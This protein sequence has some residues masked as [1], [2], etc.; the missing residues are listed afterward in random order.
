[1][2]VHAELAAHVPGGRL[3]RARVPRRARA[4]GVL[5][6][7]RDRLGLK[8]PVAAAAHRGV[9]DVI[10]LP[11]ADDEL[12]VSAGGQ[13]E[14][15]QREAGDLQ[16]VHGR[17]RRHRPERALDDLPHRGLEREVE[18][19][20]VLQAAIVVSVRFRPRPQLASGLEHRL[21]RVQRLVQV[22]KPAR[23]VQELAHPRRRHLV[24][25]RDVDLL[26]LARVLVVPEHGLGRAV[27]VRAG[28]HRLERA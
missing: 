15:F 20:D 23:A 24:D 11:E 4:E 10:P 26:A 14:V 9:D 8:R 28:V 21:Q 17:A 13:R 6:A 19:D 16:D 12:V 27:E 22:P 2:R 18:V 25:G 3:Q 1:M 7:V 5:H